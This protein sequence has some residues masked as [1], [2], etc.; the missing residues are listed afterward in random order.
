LGSQ[1]GALM[2]NIVTPHADAVPYRADGY[3]TPLHRLR[4]FNV[5]DF[6]RKGDPK[7]GKFSGR[8]SRTKSPAIMFQTGR[9]KPK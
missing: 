5:S 9:N 4:V 2:L 3:D 8:D 6:A 1:D 7:Y